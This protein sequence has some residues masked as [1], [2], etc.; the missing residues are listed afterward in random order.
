MFA[1]RN[2]T[3]FPGCLWITL[4][5]L[6]HGLPAL[7]GQGCSKPAVQVSPAPIILEG[8]SRKKQDLQALAR[9]LSSE[10]ILAMAPTCL[11][12]DL[13]RVLMAHLGELGRTQ[14]FEAPAEK[15][16]ARTERKLRKRAWNA[17]VKRLH[18]LDRYCGQ[19]QS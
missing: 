11:N 2:F 4:F 8:S 10:D 12:E 18:N 19:L 7:A 1:I 9:S 17:V 6:G 14:A 16:G 5:F 15:E 3:A 13:L